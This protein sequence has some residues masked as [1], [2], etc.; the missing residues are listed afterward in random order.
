M[1]QKTWKMAEALAYGYSSDS[2]QR[3]LSNEYLN[4]RVMKIFIIFCFFV[5]RIKVTSA[6]EMLPTPTCLLC[7]LF[8]QVATERTSRKRWGRTPS[9]NPWRGRLTKTLSYAN[10][11]ITWELVSSLSLTLFSLY[12]FS[13]PSVLPLFVPIVSASHG[14][15]KV[16]CL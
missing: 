1:M 3:E 10:N 16:V 9:A 4:D 6:S 13:L 11:C 12:P 2:T 5:H 7:S 14:S 8:S 15:L